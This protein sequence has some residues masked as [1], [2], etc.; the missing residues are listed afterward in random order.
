MKA[1]VKVMTAGILAAAA[2]MFTFRAGAQESQSYNTHTRVGN[3]WH[4]YTTFSV[5]EQGL[6]TGHT[7][8]KNCNNLRGFTGGLFVVA[9]DENNE[10]V[11]TSDVHKWGINACFFRKYR[12]RNVSWGE[13]IPAELLP[14]IQKLAVMQMHT[15]THRVLKWVYDNRTLVINH[16][17]YVADLFEKIRNKELTGEDVFEI[18]EAHI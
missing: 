10:A 17:K 16:A 9:L 2:V 3:G 6:V 12:E 7:R 15:P 8:L 14:R 4:M 13:R 1:Q 5:N 11:Y 18:I